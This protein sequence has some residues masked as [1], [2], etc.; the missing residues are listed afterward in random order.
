MISQYQNGI[1]GNAVKAEHDTAQYSEA[2]AN[3]RFDRALDEV[4]EQVRGLNQYIDEQKPWEIH[5]QGDTDHLREVLAYQVS[6]ILEIAQLLEPF[7]PETAQKIRF[8]FEEGVIR[9]LETTLF[10][11]REAA[12]KKD[13]VKKA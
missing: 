5:K 1:I 7:M 11:R 4:W 6:C 3:C 10:P 9:Q 13:E 8:V 2:L 12:A